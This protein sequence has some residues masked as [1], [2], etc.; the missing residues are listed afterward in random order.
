M[1]QDSLKTIGKNQTPSEEA[2]LFMVDEVKGYDDTLNKDFFEW[3]DFVCW[4]TLGLQQ[5]IF[6]RAMDIYQGEKIDIKWGCCEVIDLNQFEIRNISN[7]KC[8]GI[9]IVYMIKNI[10]NEIVL[11]KERRERDGTYSAWSLQ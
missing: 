5:W 10:L 11:A 3:S 1:N 7:Q 2:I 9:K 6:S 4:E 8:I